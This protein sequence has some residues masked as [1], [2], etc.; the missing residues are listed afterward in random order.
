MRVF[1]PTY[2]YDSVMEFG[3]REYGGRIMVHCMSGLRRHDLIS[4][5]FSEKAN[6]IR[7]R[8][9]DFPDLPDGFVV[10][11][12]V[13][14]SALYLWARGLSGADGTELLDPELD[15]GNELMAGAE[16]SVAIGD[17]TVLSS[18]FGIE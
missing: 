10:S 16:G 7:K 1:L 4:D 2:T 12:S 3:K 14:G 13:L 5:F 18:D 9:P 11:P 15:L 17:A 6:V 8:L